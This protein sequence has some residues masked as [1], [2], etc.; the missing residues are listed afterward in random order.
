MGFLSI[1]LDM[2]G[3]EALVVGAGRVGRRKLADLLK[4]GAR[5]RVVEPNPDESVLALASEGRIRLE[6][7]FSES[8][9]DLRPLIF[10]AA[11]DPAEGSRLAALARSRGLWINVADQPID[12][13]FHMPA[14]ADFEPL[15]LSVTTDGASPALSAAIARELRERYRAHGLLA[16]MLAELRPLVLARPLAPEKRREILTSLAEDCLLLSLLAEGRER[17]ARARAEA[18]LGPLRP[19][20]GFSALG[21]DG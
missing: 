18:L 21:V 1:N 10:V 19:P 16:R 6:P 2:T 12:C 3:R 20:E 13:D 11:D 4:A 17:E 8:F 14:V 7:E 15:R 5:V 9:L